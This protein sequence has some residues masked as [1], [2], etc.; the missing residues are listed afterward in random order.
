M[1]QTEIIP[2]RQRFYNSKLQQPCKFDF[3][4][5]FPID[6]EAVCFFLATGFFLNDSTYYSNIK[7]IKPATNMLFEEK[8]AAEQTRYWQWHY[9]PREI[10]FKQAVEEFAHIFENISQRQLAGKQIILPLSGGLDSRSQAVALTEQNDVYSYSYKFKGGI[11]EVKYG[12][13]IAKAKGF[14]FKNFTVEASYLWNYIEELADINQ[15]FSEF[16]HPRQMAIFDEFKTMGNI[17]YLGHWGDVLFDNNG[18]DDGLDN[19]AVLPLIYKKII[20]KGGLEI[21]QKMW[22]AWDLPGIF[23]EV[24]KGRLL[25]LLDEIK[26][27]NANARL[28][29]FKSLHWAPRWTSINLGVFEKEHPLALP[30]YHEDMCKFI[31]TLPEEYLAGRKIQIEYIKMKSPELAAIPWQPYDPC[32]L[33]NYKDFG[34]GKAVAVRAYRK[35]KRNINS[36]LLNNQPVQRNWELQFLGAENDRNLQNYLFEN[37]SFKKLVPQELVREFYKNFK[38]KDAVRYSHPLSMLLTLSLFSKRHYKS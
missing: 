30:Y 12:E 20:K 2:F 18:V 3:N 25:A 27:D 1:I 38:E 37:D 28:R 31:C 7:V 24:L 14:S 34:K 5:S 32:N 4:A 22:Q 21:G 35:L 6:K 19:E 36:H 13:A 11:K 8:K 15:C 10:S 9:S 16:T 17:F 33:Y 23:E 26:I 29:A